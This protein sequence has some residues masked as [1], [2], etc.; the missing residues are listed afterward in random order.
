M[1]LAT[2][3]SALNQKEEYFQEEFIR[4][5]IIFEKSLYGINEYKKT[6]RLLKKVENFDIKI[7]FVYLMSRYKRDIELKP[8]E[9]LKLIS[10]Y[11]LGQLG[12]KWIK[13]IDQAQ[14]SN[15]RNKNYDE[16]EILL[17][18]PFPPYKK[19]LNLKKQSI[20]F[21]EAARSLKDL[22]NIPESLNV[23]GIAG[24]QLNNDTFR[25]L[26]LEVA[27]DIMI[28]NNQLVK[29]MDCY[30]NS[31]KFLAFEKEY[32]LDEWESLIQKRIKL[33]IKKLQKL[34][35]IEKY[36]KGYVD[37][38]DARYSE[39]KAQA[40]IE[41]ALKYIDIIEKYQK[42]VY[43]AAARAY[44]IKCLLKLADKSSLSSI[45][46]SY[47]NANIKKIEIQ[48][49]YS[50]GIRQKLPD[51][52]LDQL[53][54]ALEMAKAYETKVRS[55]PV[56]TRA[57]TKANEE[58]KAFFLNDFGLYRGEVM[59]A[60]A[61]HSLLR[62]ID[63]DSADYWVN[64]ANQWFTKLKEN[65]QA[66]ENFNVPFKAIEISRPPSKERSSDNLGNVDFSP[67][68]YDKIFN[69]KTT[70]WYIEYFLKELKMKEG[71]I[72]F[73]K[74]DYL[75]AEQIWK[76]LYNMDSFY[77]ESEKKGFGSTV[78]RLIWN[79][80]NNQGALYA[81]PNEM[82]SFRNKRLRTAVLL[83]D[84]DYENE[85]REKALEQY[86]LIESGAFGKL[87]RN[88]SAYINYP[89]GACYLYG[90]IGKEND[91]RKRFF[92]YLDEF[93]GTPSEVR[94]LFALANTLVCNIDKK[95]D[96]VK[97]LEIYEYIVKSF[98]NE[99]EAEDSLFYLV[100]FYA[101][102]QN[103]KICKLYCDLYLKKYPSGKWINFLKRLKKDNYI[104]V[105]WR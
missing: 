92:K 68:S 9:S 102:L 8:I 94:A 18:V 45:Q 79:A 100:S 47:K 25:C 50:Q 52:K 43:S 87:D 86:L 105:D 83:A 48:D 63:L 23:I 28:E 26:S 2:S 49:R 51:V 67:L 44:K 33:K 65:D 19:W 4:Q 84:L 89:I 5:A 74:G 38:R 62:K 76:E 95:D 103:P 31:L 13:K 41:A 16:K 20:L 24:K 90:V 42:T 35:N 1:L 11:I 96:C 53:K 101:N 61:E 69:R 32:G 37:Y 12:E 55:F 88:Q 98:P 56:G 54:H 93:R 91:W 64:R 29:S 75:K 3:A 72:L 70:S 40:Y 104:E 22:K 27:A 46:K 7:K 97:G 59:Y 60:F 77:V 15:S 21:L 14:K 81:T 30:K 39:L 73:A 85:N 66:L 17:H 58:A 57:W 82:K 10:P 80:K 71:F 6:V 99:P 78:Q 34:I 36:G